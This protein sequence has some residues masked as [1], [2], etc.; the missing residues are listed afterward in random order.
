MAIALA[1]CLTFIAFTAL[2]AARVVL[3]LYA[4]TLGAPASSVGVLGGMFYLFPLLLSWPIGALS[5]RVGAVTGT[6]ALLLPYSV[7]EVGAF[8]AAAALCGL[9]IAFYHVTLQNLVGVLSK[10]EQRARNFSNFS[11][12]G[13]LTSFVGPLIA[14]IS[15]DHI[16]HAAAAL[17]IVGIS[18]A[19]FVV[20]PIGWRHLPKP[21]PAAP[22]AAAAENM[23]ADPGIWRMLAASAMVQL[24]TDLFQFYIPIYG[25][26]IG[27]SASAIGSVLASFAAAAFVV[28]IFLPRLVKQAKPDNVLMFSFYAGALGFVVVPFVTQVPLLMLASFCFGLGMGCGTPLTVMLMFE[29]SS[30]GRSGRT[31]G[32]RLTTTNA[33]RA[34]GPMI[35]GAI[36]TAFGVPAVFWINGALMAAQGYWTKR[37]APKK[38][39]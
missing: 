20:L 37:T 4:L 32:I 3:T 29:R 36:G 2:N 10:P 26:A 13:A 9:S 7:R 17:V 11:L 21:K 8:Y 16:G 6:A 19:A 35:F 12:V 34:F 15:I 30:A 23:P 31:L 14:G 22:K 28:R 1:F 25:H 33:V 38:T 39:I 24:G 18:A 5:D 27:L